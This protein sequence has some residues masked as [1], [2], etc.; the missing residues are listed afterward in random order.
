MAN[1]PTKNNPVRESSTGTKKRS[2]NSN[3]L[4][5]ERKP[6]RK[7]SQHKN[8]EAPEDERKIK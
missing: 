7:N 3:K 2:E 5:K 6:E 8:K 1:K 4:K